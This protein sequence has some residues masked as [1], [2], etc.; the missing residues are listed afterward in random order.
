MRGAW[1]SHPEIIL[2]GS[3]IIYLGVD[4]PVYKLDI[5]SDSFSLKFTGD[6]SSEEI[7]D[8]IVCRSHGVKFRIKGMEAFRIP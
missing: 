2:N 5:K 1:P 3:E 6:A 7:A 4:D 8:G